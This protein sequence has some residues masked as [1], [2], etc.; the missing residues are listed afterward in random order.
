MTD[1]YSINPGDGLMSSEALKNIEDIFQS[2]YARAGMPAGMALFIR[3]ETEGRLHCE[4]TVYLSPASID[5]AQAIGAVPCVQPVPT[6]L[7]LLL[8]NV[9]CWKVLFP[10]YVNK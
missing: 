9:D 2:H 7:S 10:D 6:N 3:H 1:W 8:G 4:V 5:V